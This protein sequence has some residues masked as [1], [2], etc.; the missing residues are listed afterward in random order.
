MARTLHA[1]GGDAE[2]REVRDGRGKLPQIEHPRESAR[3]AQAI[4][5]RL[6]GKVHAGISVTVSW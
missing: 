1:G 4:R 5:R 3:G 2:A 6:T